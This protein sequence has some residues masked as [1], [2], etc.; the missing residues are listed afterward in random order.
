MI[1]VKVPAT[2][3]NLGPGFDCM[4]LALGMYNIVEAEETDYGLEIGATGRDLELIE[5]DQ[6]NLIVKAIKKVCN[7][8]GYPLKGLRLNCI[9]NIPV[10][11]G[12]GS[13]AACTAAGLIIGNELSGKNL[14]MDDILHMGIEME[15]H[16]DNIVPA[17]LGGMYISCI[18][19]GEK[20][21]YVRVKFPDNLKFAVM[22]PD[23]TLSTHYA[24]KVL[25]RQVDYKD[26]VFNISR[27]A[28][29]VAALVSGELQYLKFSTE[30]R[31]HQ[32]YRKKLIPDID[33][34]FNY[35]YKEGAMATFISGAGSSIIAM[36]DRDDY[37]FESRIQDKIQALTHKWEIYCVHLSSEGV[38]ATK[39]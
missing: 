18:E 7:E 30:D 36:L 27:A 19:S 31:L 16:P 12:L 9:N 24:R 1:R 23:F 2:T 5:Y 38:T 26:A 14:E 21:R 6:N 35:C 10:A 34:V 32:P 4:G 33:K 37:L 8:V 22:I 3:A 25:P 17:V 20:A 13:S 28:F 15:G 29:L 11:R 39:T